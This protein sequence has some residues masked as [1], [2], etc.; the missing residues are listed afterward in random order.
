MKLGRFAFGKNKG[1]K[2]EY[3]DPPR[4]FLEH[5]LELRACLINC[6]TAWLAS[7]CV[8]L[9]LAKYVMQWIMAPA[10][11]YKDLITPLDV[12]SGVELILKIMMW[13]GTALSFPFLLFF[14]MRF[15]FPGL[16]RSERS[17]ITF[18][19]AA[20]T[21]C[22]VCGVWMAYAKILAIA[23]AFLMRINAW[24]GMPNEIIQASTFITFA[25]K[26][27]IAFGV[28]FQMPLV[29]LALGWLG[30]ISSDALRRHRRIAIVVIFAMAMLLTPPDFI[31]QPMMALPMCLL[32]EVC[33]WVIR[34]REI[35]RKKADGEPG[36]E[37]AGT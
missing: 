1:G 12:T 16:K 18:C 21:V 17:L 34:L 33:I 22:F 26:T 29:L 31:S 19:I 20:S 36:A 30:I 6:A 13:G 14:A 10:G 8:M 32:Y 15:V 11:Q 24:L 4:P 5:L 27:I 9:P 35:A 7:V 25:V 2:D 23:I 37:V 3:N 28:A